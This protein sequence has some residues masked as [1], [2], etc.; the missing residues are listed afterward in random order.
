MFLVLVAHSGTSLIGHRNIQS[1]ICSVSTH[2][3]QPNLVITA[4]DEGLVR[5]HDFRS[6]GVGA[7][8][9]MEGLL[10]R[11][12][13]INDAQWCPAAGASHSF[14]VAQA[15][16][17]VWYAYPVSFSFL[18]SLKCVIRD[19]LMFLG[20]PDGLAHGVLHVYRS[21]RGPQTCRPTCEALSIGFSPAF[22]S[23]H[24]ILRISM[25]PGFPNQARLP[26]AHPSQ[27][28]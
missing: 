7:L 28:A 13:E 27:P 18:G 16:G 2:P 12:S 5:L 10:V 14:V 26:V 23:S 4:D 20:W 1:T 22:S 21:R 11:N 19:L 6:P 15:D 17:N 24:T 9:S 8:P 3:T 25:Q